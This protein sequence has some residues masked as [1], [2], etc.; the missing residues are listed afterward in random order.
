MNA[1]E[2]KLASYQG[3]IALINDAIEYAA[4]QG[5]TSFVLDIKLF[6]SPFWT[7]PFFDGTSK[8]QS[9]ESYLRSRNYQLIP[10]NTLSKNHGESVVVNWS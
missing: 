9:G 5:Q 1:Q 6:N 4:R 3:Y 10:W 7:N 8:H 2:A